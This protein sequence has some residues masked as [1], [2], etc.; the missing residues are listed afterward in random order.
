MDKAQMVALMLT[1]KTPVPG[2][3]EPLLDH[4]AELLEQ[5]APRLDDDE[6]YPLI[7]VGA[8]IYQRWCQHS[9]AEQEA[10]E[11]LLRLNGGG[12]GDA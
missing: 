10:A 7:A 12:E 6:L 8:A 3:W 5:I 9:A 2:G 4:Y 1:A 11:A